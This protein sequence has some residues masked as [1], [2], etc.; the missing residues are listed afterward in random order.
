MARTKDYLPTLEKDLQRRVK[1]LGLWAPN[2][3]AR[4]GGMGI[5]YIGQALMNEIV[6]RAVF[7]RDCLAM[8]PPD[9]GNAE[10]FSN[11]GDR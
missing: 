4:V 5:G 10:L 2:L 1:E 6:G 8:P 3:P 7:R 9:A 11:R